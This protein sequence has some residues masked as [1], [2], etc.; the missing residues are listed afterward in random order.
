LSLNFILGVTIYAL[1]KEER[2]S[3]ESGCNDFAYQLVRTEIVRKIIQEQ[4]ESKRTI[5]EGQNS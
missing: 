3:G 5:E 2:G 4:K 1:D